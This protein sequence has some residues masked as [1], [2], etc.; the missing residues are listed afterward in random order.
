MIVTEAVTPFMK[1][2]RQRNHFEIFGIDL[3]IDDN[4]DCWL[5]EINRKPSFGYSVQNAEKENIFLDNM[6]IE[7][8]QMV[9]VDSSLSAKTSPA[10]N[11]SNNTKKWYKVSEGN[12]PEQISTAVWKNLFEWKAFTKLCRKKVMVSEL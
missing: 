4:R 6:L 3:I 1:A 8:L 10:Q 7:L 12:D 11:A 9:S 5:I 2:Q